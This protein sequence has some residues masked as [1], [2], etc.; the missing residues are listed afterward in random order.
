RCFSVAVLEGGEELAYRGDMKNEDGVEWYGL[1]VA[2]EIYFSE[3][4]LCFSTNPP[5]DRRYYCAD[6]ES[7][8]IRYLTGEQFESARSAG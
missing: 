8:T 3:G 6:I 5:E 4:R 1:F 7:G 2:Q